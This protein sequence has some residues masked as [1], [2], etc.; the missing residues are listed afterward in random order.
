MLDQS[1]KNLNSEKDYS[2]N[3]TINN[4]NTENNNEEIPPFKSLAEESTPIDNKIYISNDMRLYIL[5]NMKNNE[6]I[7]KKDLDDATFEII[8]GNKESIKVIF[9]DPS[10]DISLYR[11]SAFGH[12]IYR[13]KNNEFASEGNVVFVLGEKQFTSANIINRLA[14]LGIK[15]QEDFFINNKGQITPPIIFNKLFVDTYLIKNYEKYEP[16][17]VNGVINISYKQASDMIN[18]F[19]KYQ[20]ENNDNVDIISIVE[21]LKTKMNADDY[22][23]TYNLAK[24]TFNIV[25]AK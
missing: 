25:E 22:S 15:G 18:D 6:V 21:N 10:Q 4:L 20:N 2:T 19:Y 16:L 24:K 12:I 9:E 3:S 5:P 8:N 7:V 1:L 13:Y 11:W 17:I 14:L 23:K